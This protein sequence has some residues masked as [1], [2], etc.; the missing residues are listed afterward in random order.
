MFGFKQ[1]WLDSSLIRE[2]RFCFLGAE[3]PSCPPSF[4]ESQQSKTTYEKSRIPSVEM[5]SL[6]RG[7]FPNRTNSLSQSG[8]PDAEMLVIESYTT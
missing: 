2:I 4:Q 7:R 5:W 6:R 8:S 3:V 1:P